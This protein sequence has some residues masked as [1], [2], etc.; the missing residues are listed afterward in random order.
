MPPNDSLPERPE[1]PERTRSELAAFVREHTASMPVPL[2]PEISV[3][4]ASEVTPL[5]H[6]TEAWLASRGIDPPFWAFPWAGGQVLA[7]YLLDTPDE[8][9]DLRVL[10]FAS[11]SGLVA[12][13]AAR[14]GAREVVAV[15]VDPLAVAATELN[16]EASGVRV[17]ARVE[18][19]TG[20]GLADRFD[21]VL[22]GD[23]FYDAGAAA[24][25]LPWF[26]ELAAAGVRVLV[27]DPGR[28]YVPTRGVSCLFRADV[29]VPLGLESRESLASRVWVVSPL[30]E[31]T[32]PTS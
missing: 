11:G 2:V 28:A 17:E 29:P 18:D 10:D 14:A 9:R 27:G 31:D 24:R 21:V 30:A 4:V 13:A 19:V 5:W 12:I 32:K 7:R 8:V 22:A 23:V 26:R 25:F 20:H 16:A 6:A 1:R 3:R 15:D